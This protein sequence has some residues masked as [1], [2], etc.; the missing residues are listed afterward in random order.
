MP[1]KSSTKTKKGLT[2]ATMIED[3][4]IKRMRKSNK[5]VKDK[6]KSKKSNKKL[7]P[8]SRSH[9]H[10]KTNKQVTSLQMKILKY[11]S[12]NKKMANGFKYPRKP[13]K[14]DPPL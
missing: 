13:K 12:P 7:K 9:N 14:D 10:K 1:Q 2:K 3:P 11:S 5:R 4:M 6:T 8:K